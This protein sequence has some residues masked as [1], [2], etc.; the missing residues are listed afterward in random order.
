VFSHGKLTFVSVMSFVG[1][2]YVKPISEPNGVLE[3]EE[4]DDL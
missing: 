1:Y 2:D 3:E 4:L